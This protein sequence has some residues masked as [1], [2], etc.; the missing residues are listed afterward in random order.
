M[1][2]IPFTVFFCGL[3]TLGSALQCYV[4]HS[5]PDNKDKCIKT[6]KQCTE[7]KD[8]CSTK[9]S[10]RQPPYWIPRAERIHMIDKDCTTR[11]DCEATRSMLGKTLRCKRY[12]YR[13]WDCVECCQGDL[14]NY[15]ATLSGSLHKPSLILVAMTAF[16]IFLL[17]LR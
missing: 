8:A 12:W 10:W 17:H 14:C 15:Y 11:S 3:L 9:I 7:D 13:D 2:L 5:Q 6:T 4:C 1:E 16:V